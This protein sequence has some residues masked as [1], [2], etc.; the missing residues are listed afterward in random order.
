MEEDQNLLLFKALHWY[1]CQ[2]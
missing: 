2:I 1:S